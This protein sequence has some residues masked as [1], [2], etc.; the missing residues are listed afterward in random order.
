[1]LEPIQIE[2]PTFFE[3]MTVNTWLLKGEENVLIDCGEKTDKC[4]QALIKG[5]ADNGLTLQDISK[6]VITHAHLDH[7]GMANRITQNCDAQIWVSQMTYEWAVNLKELLDR[8][9][10][11]TRESFAPNFTE[12]QR[13]EFKDFGYQKLSP[14]WD[15]IPPDRLEIFPMEGTVNL[16]GNEWEIIHTPGHCLNQT[17]FYQKE[18]GWLLSADMLLP[19]ISM[20]IVD[21][22]R[23][24]PYKGVKSLLMHMA[25]YDKLLQRNITK[26]FPGHYPAFE[27]VETVIHKQLSKISKRKEKC[28]DLIGQGVANF[29]DLTKAIYPDRV[30]NGTMF[31]ILGYLQMLEEE[32]RIK[33]ELINGINHY[34]LIETAVF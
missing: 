34:K 21:A 27:E 24:P 18:K 25:S 2:L 17:C 31:M 20:P 10:K 8:R 28:F 5:L 23:T 12:E 9:S 22:E 33:A 6:V 1:M 13:A 4:W 3:V 11:A 15:E 26:A 19:M 7:M 32:D 30:H 29:M 14:Y 16:A